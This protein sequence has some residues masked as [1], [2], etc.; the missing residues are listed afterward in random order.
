MSWDSKAGP[1][2]RLDKLL[3]QAG[4]SSAQLAR[5]LKIDPST[6]TKYRNGTRVPDANTLAYL[7]KRAGGSA[8]EVLGLKPSVPSAARLRQHVA[9]LDAVREKISEALKNQE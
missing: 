9:E 1:A 2:A 3:E 8:D 6:V 7:V 4:L 5:E